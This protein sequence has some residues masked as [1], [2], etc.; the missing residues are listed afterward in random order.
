LAAGPFYRIIDGPNPGPARAAIDRFIY[1]AEVLYTGDAQTLPTRVEGTVWHSNLKEARYFLGTRNPVI[2]QKGL[3]Q[4]IE[5]DK[6]EEA[7]LLMKYVPEAFP[8][9]VNIADVLQGLRLPN[10]TTQ[11]PT[12]QKLLTR[13]SQTLRERFPEGFF[14]KPV[15]GFNAVGTFPTEKSD[16]ASIYEAYLRDVKP[17]I[18]KRLRE[19]HGDTDTVHLE[20]KNLPNYSGRVLEDLLER[21]QSVIAQAKIQGAVGS[22]VRTP[23]GPKALLAEYRVHIV[24]GRVLSGATQ[25]RWEDA[26]GATQDALTGVDAFAQSVIDRLPPTLRRMCF[27]MDVMRTKNGLYQVIELNPGGESGYLYPDTDLWVA[28]LLAGHYQEGHTPVLDEFQRFKEARGLAAKEALLDQLLNRPEL[29]ELTRA[30]GPVT[31][32]LAQ[33]K[34]VLL[35]EALASPTRQSA[36]LA[37]MTLK[38]FHL[39]AYLTGPEVETLAN[40]IGRAAAAETGL[41]LERIG[42]MLSLQDGELLFVGSEGQI[43]LL[44]SMGYTDLEVEQTL[45]RRLQDRINSGW[46]GRLG[47]R[48]LTPAQARSEAE[49]LINSQVATREDLTAGRVAM[50]S[51]ARELRS[52]DLLPIFYS[53]SREALIRRLIE[54]TLVSLV[55]DAS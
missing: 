1:G 23:Q 36:L 18:E 51:L 13:L 26:R 10:A 7:K 15:A 43:R 3:F 46:D 14:L 48:E 2:E 27:G 4:L 12:R 11:L 42:K 54:Q 29:A 49:Q 32:L 34:T 55:K 44:A 17:Q 22:I 33:A 40:L 19:T 21:P 8:T 30:V 52:D 28:Q 6:W 16:F 50:E 9:T 31:E 47:E 24:E 5:N 37:L 41:P 25:T 53:G 20:L 35:K 45:F 39:T 38:K